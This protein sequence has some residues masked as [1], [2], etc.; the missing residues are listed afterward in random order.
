VLFSATVVVTKARELF[1]R[2]PGQPLTSV[3]I[4]NRTL[5]EAAGSIHGML[6]PLR[7][8]SGNTSRLRGL[9]F[10]SRWLCFDRTRFRFMIIMTNYALEFGVVL[11]AVCPTRA[12]LVG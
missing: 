1:V 9:N 7:F 4:R 12:G 8:T 10:F 2:F 6:T 5:T 11:R 3:R